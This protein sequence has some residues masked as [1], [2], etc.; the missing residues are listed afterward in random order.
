MNRLTR[1]LLGQFFFLFL[2]S[3]VF[4]IFSIVL[5]DLLMN[6]SKLVPQ[7]V[8]LGQILMLSYLYIPRA[9]SWSLSPSLLFAVSFVLGNLYSHNELVVVFGSG[10]SLRRFTAPLFLV[11]L[12][13]SA[14]LFVWNDRGV[15]GAEAQRQELN[16]TL[17]GIATKNNSNVALLSNGGQLLYSAAFY[18]DQSK[19]LT[20]VILVWKAADG[21]FLKRLDA[22]WGEWAKGTWVFHKVKTYVP[23]QP[24]RVDYR[25]DEQWS[26]PA[27]S[28]PPETFQKKNVEVEEL[29]FGQSLEYVQTLKKGGLPSAEVE[30]DALQR[31]SFSFSPFVVIWISAAIGGRFRK[32]ILL[33]SL[34]VS[35]LVSASYVVL[36]MV[37]GLLSKTG[38][39]PP[40]LGAASGVIVGALAGFYLFTRART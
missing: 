32:N 4:F 26:D 22:E 40:W 13:A 7:G 35:L 15:I 23:G 12:L 11:G 8:G 17:Q 6:L 1:Y 9:L 19:T 29:T 37:F 18:N 25:Y 24:G 10:I 28:D 36:Q 30:T 27:V 39:L 20:G 33:M 31:I 21:T 14:F 3:L 34:L 38:V 2:L 5:S 16:R